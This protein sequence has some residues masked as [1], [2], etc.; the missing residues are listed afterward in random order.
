MVNPWR[1]LRT[2]HV[3][4]SITHQPNRRHDAQ[5]HQRQNDDTHERLTFQDRHLVFLPHR[6]TPFRPVGAFLQRRRLSYSKG[7]NGSAGGALAG[8]AAS[9]NLTEY[10]APQSP[11]NRF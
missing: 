8:A 2:F 9:R 3:K 4:P 5:R 7:M 10:S 6:H 11:Q 1:Q